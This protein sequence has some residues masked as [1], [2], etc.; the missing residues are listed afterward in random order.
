MVQ[1]DAQL[2]EN[3]EDVDKDN[4]NELEMCLKE[5]I[6]KKNHCSAN[7]TTEITIRVTKM[8]SHWKHKNKVTRNQDCDEH[9]GRE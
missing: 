1:A 9:P 2:D 6:S 3:D 7:R 5:K 4:K 8:M